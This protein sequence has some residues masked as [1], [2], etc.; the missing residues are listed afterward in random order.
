ML[1][2]PVLSRLKRKVFK[3]PHKWKG[4]SKLT[5]S[6]R[7]EQAL[8]LRMKTVVNTILSSLIK[9]FI[10]L[11][12]NCS[13]GYKKRINSNLSI[14]PLREEKSFSQ[15]AFSDFTDIRKLQ[16]KAKTSYTL[17]TRRPRGL[18]M[19]NSLAEV[20]PELVSEWSEKN[21]PWKPDEI[22]AKSRKNVWWR[23]GMWGGYPPK[24]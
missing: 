16:D 12:V 10:K 2:F 23:Y 8:S 24:D 7:Q 6:L 17:S 20:H 15:R 9:E 4:I 14:F 21:L 11:I 5:S 13:E 1:I 22:K 3:M 19:N 18:T